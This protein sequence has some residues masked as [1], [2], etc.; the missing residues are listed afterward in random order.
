MNTFLIR[1]D[2]VQVDRWLFRIRTRLAQYQEQNRVLQETAANLQK[3]VDALE[4]AA[5]ESLV[6]KGSKPKIDMTKS[7]DEWSGH[8]FVRLFQDLFASKYNTNYQVRGRQWQAYAM[9][10]KQFRNTY[11]DIR[12]N[13]VYK[14][15]IEWLFQNA[16]N[17]KF[18]ASIPLIT[19]DAMLNQWRA[20]TSGKRNTTPEQFKAI[21][22]RAP[23]TTKDID[24]I[25]GSF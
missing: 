12:D 14:D 9:R 15:M 16:F 13:N 25:M 23:K 21:A 22:A 1:E 4:G 11:D 20:A 5:S 24:D 3:S 7:V 17:K 10:I 19:S 8:H 2:P 18:I 6:V